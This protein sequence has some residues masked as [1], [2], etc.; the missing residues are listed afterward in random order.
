[1][2]NI[3]ESEGRFFN[4][5]IYISKAKN[6]LEIGCGCGYSTIW[7]A[8]AARRNNGKVATIDFSK[9]SYQQAEKNIYN[10]GFSDTVDLYFGNAIDVIP[11]IIKPKKFDFVFVD[12]EKRHYWD[13]WIT[14][15][16]RLNKKAIVIFDNVILF[17]DKT[18][19]FM[20]KIKHVI[21]FEQIVLPIDK[22]DGIILLY[23]IS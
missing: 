4:M 8:D 6:I 15:A 10:S 3:S 1:M 9:P 2:P 12:G 19:E 18:N 23:K 7:L 14:I 22:N 17:P 20:K 21:G 16:N 11:K 5:L 13:F